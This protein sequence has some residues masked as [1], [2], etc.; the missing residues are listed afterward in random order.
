MEWED[1]VLLVE[2]YM[3]DAD[4]GKLKDVVDTLISAGNDNEKERKNAE[5]SIRGLLKGWFLM[6][7]TSSMVRAGEA[8]M[9][10]PTNTHSTRRRKF[11]QICKGVL[12]I[13]N[14]MVL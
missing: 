10:V 5:F 1:L 7:F 9:P 8:D 14:G 3:E 13:R 12:P 6:D 4:L 11:Q 2:A